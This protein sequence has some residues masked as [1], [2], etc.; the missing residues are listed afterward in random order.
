MDQDA[1]SL[2]KPYARIMRLVN[3]FAPALLYG[4]WFSVLVLS[5]LISRRPVYTEVG[6][7]EVTPP[8]Q[9]QI[10]LASS[11]FMLL[12]ALAGLGRLRKIMAQAARHWG[13]SLSLLA[14]IV[15][16]FLIAFARG[17]LL[18]MAY[19]VLMFAAVFGAAAIWQSTPRAQS[20]LLMILAGASILT[21]ALGLA[22][23]GMPVI[24]WIGG[25]HPNHIGFL[26][27]IIAVYGWRLRNIPGLTLFA[28]G[29]AIAV[30]V[31][32]RYAIVCIGLV[33]GT[34]FLL[35]VYRRFGMLGGSAILLGGAF[36]LALGATTIGRDLLLLNDPLRGA[37]TGGTGRAQLNETSWAQIGDHLIWGAGFR[38]K[39]GYFVAHN[40]YLNFLNETGLV[41]STFFAIFLLLTAARAIAIL[42]E[43]ASGVGQTNRVIA[44][45]LY[46][47][48]LLAAMFQPQIVNFGDSQGFILFFG[49]GVTFTGLGLAQ[50]PLAAIAAEPGVHSRQKPVSAAAIAARAES[51]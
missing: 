17:S 7:I 36:V 23:F 30:L 21:V 39:D 3:E 19:V 13:A 50:G 26:A 31:S 6:P 35:L 42:F 28:I 15:S 32:S 49:I 51:S 43:P 22:I 4:A 29:S 41:S 38:N 2:S 40:G 14:T 27:L 47:S 16:M 18:E 34:D 9:R 33:A 5:L 11:G 10:V 1:L 12:G 8:I 48:V 20:L 45:Q 37:G 46:L 44:A 25:M 24:R